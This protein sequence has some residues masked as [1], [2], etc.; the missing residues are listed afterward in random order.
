MLIPWPV[1]LWLLFSSACILFDFFYIYLR[2]L[3]FRYNP[4]EWTFE[5]YQLYQFFDTLKINM[6]D[7]F[8]VIQSYLNLVEAALMLLT[9]LVALL[10]FRRLKYVC[11]IIMLALV[12][13][14]FWK[15]VIYLVYDRNFITVSV[16]RFYS[17]AV[18]FYYFTIGQWIVFPAWIGF[19]ICRR[20]VKLASGEEVK[21]I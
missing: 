9:A 16:K 19:A 21:E 7:R 6:E 17:I 10:P 18:V 8:L 3:S 13:C 15:T 12:S 1:Y 11:G 14:V 2:P 20:I 5:P 4:Y